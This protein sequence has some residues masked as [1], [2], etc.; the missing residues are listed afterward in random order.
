MLGW[1]SLFVIQN[2]F[3]KVPN[4]PIPLHALSGALVSEGKKHLKKSI[5]CLLSRVLRAGI[6]SIKNSTKIVEHFIELL[7]F[8][9]QWDFETPTPAQFCA[10]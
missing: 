3:Y 5:E 1:D 4:V 7:R 9:E 8:I 6:G 10:I 2:R